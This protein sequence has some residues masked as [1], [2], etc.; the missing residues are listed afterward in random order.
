MGMA[1]PLS[2]VGSGLSI[3]V[4][5]QD[6]RGVVLADTAEPFL[7]SSKTVPGGRARSQDEATCPPATREPFARGR[8]G[9]ETGV[10]PAQRD[11]P[12]TPAHQVER[13]GSPINAELK[14]CEPLF[15][16]ALVRS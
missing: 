2:W 15:H 4:D 14:Y 16:A 10:Q 9:F 12:D 5:V 1:Y 13:P 8:L 7:T 6:G 11:R 3:R